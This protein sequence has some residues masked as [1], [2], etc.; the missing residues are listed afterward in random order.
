MHNKVILLGNLGQDPTM[1]YM[2]D[3]TAVTNFRVATKKKK[4]NAE[5][6]QMK[7][8]VWVR[9]SAWNKSA[10]VINEHFIKGQAIYVEGR[11]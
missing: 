8:T 7:E 5:G 6:E 9:C 2:A 4:K 11:L 10:E 3:G 1:S